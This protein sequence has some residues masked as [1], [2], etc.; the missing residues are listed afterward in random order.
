M[1]KGFVAGLQAFAERFRT[2]RPGYTFYFNT[3]KTAW[4]LV[5][6][7]GHHIQRALLSPKT[8]GE[9]DV[10][11]RTIFAGKREPSPLEAGNIPLIEMTSFKKGGSYYV[12]N[13]D[14]QSDQ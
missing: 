1:E 8:V 7:N 9:G 6:V 13:S 10:L 11:Q 4:E 2:C 12:G 14:R 3:D 5:T